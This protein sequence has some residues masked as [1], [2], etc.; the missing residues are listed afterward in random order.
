MWDALSDKMTGLSFTIAAGPRQ[1]SQSRFRDLEGQVLVVIS[2]RN[3]VAQ[4]YLKAL[5]SF[6]VS[7]DLRGYEGVRTRLHAV[8]I[9]ESALLHDLP[10]TP[11][12]SSWDQAP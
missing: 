2:L 12:S 6:F 3:R 4:L 8:N 5:G 11:I 9:I 10:F 1:H 7:H